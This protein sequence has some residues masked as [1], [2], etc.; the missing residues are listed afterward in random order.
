MEKYELIYVY[1]YYKFVFGG[2]RNFSY[3]LE[4]NKYN[5]YEVGLF[6]VES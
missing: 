2:L 1:Y 6:F 5:C 4:N 3:D